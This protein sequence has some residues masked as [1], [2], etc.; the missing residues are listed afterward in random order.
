MKAQQTF[1]AMFEDKLNSL[2]P[3]LVK[4]AGGNE[5]LIQEGAIGIWES[6]KEQPYATNKYHTTKA[7]WNI[8]NVARGVGRSVDIPK[9][10][11][12]KFPITVIH[13]DAIPDNADA[14]LSQAMLTDRNGLPLDEMVIRKMDFERFVATLTTTEERYIRFKMVDELPDRTAAAALSMSV[15]KLHALKMTLRGKIEDHF[16]A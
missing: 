9:Q 5:D 15:E 12:R 11:P 13:Y 16:T 10:Y 7:K 8:V 1:D 14:D 4:T 6:M 3:Y 2:M